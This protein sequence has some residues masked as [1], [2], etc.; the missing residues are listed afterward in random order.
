[1]LTKKGD[2]LLL[3]DHVLEIVTKLVLLARNQRGTAPDVHISTQ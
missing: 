3:S 1:M 2:F